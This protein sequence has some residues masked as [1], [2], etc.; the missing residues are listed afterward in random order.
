MGLYI[1]GNAVGGMSGRIGSALLCEHLPWHTAIGIIG[2]FSLLLSLV[3]L[4]SLPPSTNFRQRPFR[5]RYLF[6]SLGQHLRDPGLLCLYGMAFLGMGG[7]VTLYN[8]IG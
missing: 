2:L 7:F 5:I 8:Y 4:K 3:F 6:T 1:S